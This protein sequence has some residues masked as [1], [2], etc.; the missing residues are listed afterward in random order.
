[1]IIKILIAVLLESWF[2]FF[3]IPFPIPFTI[4]DISLF[5][6]KDKTKFTNELEMHKQ[7]LKQLSD[8]LQKLK[9]AKDNLPEVSKSVINLYFFLFFTICCWEERSGS[10][11]KFPNKIL[12]QYTIIQKYYFNFSLSVFSHTLPWQYIPWK[13]SI[14]WI[15]FSLLP[16]FTFFSSICFKFHFLWNKK[17]QLLPHS[18]DVSWELAQFTS[19]ACI[20]DVLNFLY[21]DSTCSI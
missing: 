6:S 2:C 1:M 20:A 12:H 11:K 15:S 21:A 7:A 14:L 19:N 16:F 9:H 4:I 13:L 17:K 18:P 5:Q 8:E 10:R 3:A